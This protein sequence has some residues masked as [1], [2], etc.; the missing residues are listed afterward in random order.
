[1]NRR[2]FLITATA[3]AGSLGAFKPGLAQSYP[4]RPVKLMVPFPPGGPLDMVARVVGDKLAARL[5]QPFILE[6]RAGAAGNLGTEAVVRSAPD[7]HTLLIVLGSTLTVNPWLYSSL[8]FDPVRDLRPISILTS[9]SQ[10][11]VVHPSIPVNSVAEFIAY[12][13]KEPISYAH[14]GHGSPGHL[15]M[16]Y[17]RLKAGFQT[18]PVPYRGNATLVPDLLGGQ[19]KFAFVATAGVVQHVRDGR[20]KGL[21][22]SAAK[23]SELAPAVP[24]VAEV[25]YPGFEVETHFVMLAPSAMPDSIADLL[26]REVR[27]AI[28]APDFAERFRAQD[29]VV[30]GSTSAHARARLKAD[31]ELWRGVVKATNMQA[32]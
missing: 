22:I 14:A 19:I 28:R 17:F 16:E 10:M 23:R 32:T 29:V 20:L 4:S 25:G 18:V 12:A 5:K 8:T 31:S 1:M 11:L 15:T 7:G 6:N 13:K 2:A 3:F 24:T 21:A 26:E 30:V 9:N 27:S